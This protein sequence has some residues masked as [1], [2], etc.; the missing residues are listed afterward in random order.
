MSFIDG[1]KHIFGMPLTSEDGLKYKVNDGEVTI[2][3]ASRKARIIGIPACID[4]FPVCVIQGFANLPFS[5]NLIFPNTVYALGEMAFCGAEEI[6]S[7]TINGH[8][9]NLGQL[10]FMGCSNIEEVFIDDNVDISSAFGLFSECSKLKKV[11][12]PECAGK[13]SDMIFADCEGLEEIFIPDNVQLISEYAFSGCKSL[14]TV[15]WPENLKEIGSGAFSE[16]D[17]LREIELPHG[18]EHIGYNA[19]GKCANLRKVIIPNTVRRIDEKAFANC[20]ILLM[21]E[22]PQGCS[23]HRNAFDR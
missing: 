10:V 14:K 1:L 5:G 20:P 6:R 21:P 18:L 3:G 8:I 9:R 15:H 23:V 17:S 12:L 13:I 4:D 7:V 16:C 19:F 22:I 2:V 11:H